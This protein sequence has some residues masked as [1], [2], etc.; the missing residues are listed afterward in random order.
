M[1]LTTVPARLAKLEYSAIRLP[2]TLLETHVV[3]RY[4]DDEAPLRLGFEHFLG[5]LDGFAGRILSDGDI[6]R[7][8][9]ALTRRAEFLAKA[10]ELD[11]KAR[12]RRAQAEEKLRAGQAQARQ[13]RQQAHTETDDKIAAAYRREQEDKQQV[14]RTADA[15]AQR[16][17]AQAEH[18]AKKRAAKAEAAKQATQK[19]ISAQQ[20]RATAATGQ[21]LSD[22][23][24]KHSSARNRR[25]E[26]DRLDQLARRERE[27]RR[28][29]NRSEGATA[30]LTPRSQGPG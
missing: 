4:L 15:R 18:T 13:A 23:A 25:Q 7:R 27:A 6:S 10:G 8:G 19:S 26:A 2:F 9:Q 1:G 3:A 14:R 21:R 22:A 20:D 16:K 28:T 29:S 17:T 12:A 24:E 30:G 5:S 11:T